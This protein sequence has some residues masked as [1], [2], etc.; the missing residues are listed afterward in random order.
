G[1]IGFELGEIGHARVLPV[2]L[3]WHGRTRQVDRKSIAAAAKPCRFRRSDMRRRPMC[4][5]RTA[6]EDEAFLR[7]QVAVSRRAVFGAVSMTAALAGC[8]T[9]AT[10]STEVVESD[11]NITTPDGTCD[12]HFAHPASGAHAAV[13]VWPDIMGLRP[14]FRTMGKRLAQ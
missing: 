11:V 4:D 7:N 8:A 9:G 5:D 3:W 1:D 13:L 14:A 6:A 12:A 10:G 2:D